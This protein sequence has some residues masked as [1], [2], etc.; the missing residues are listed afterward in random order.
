MRSAAGEAGTVPRPVVLTVPR[1]D[2]RAPAL[3]PCWTALWR[4]RLL[5]WAAGCVAFLALGTASGALHAFDPAGTS[6]SFGSLGNVLAAPAVRW[7]SIWYLQIAHDGY[8]FAQEASFYPLYPIL[9]RVGSLLTGSLVIAGLLL[10][11]GAMFAGLVIVRRLTELE[12]G[13]RPA[14]ATVNLIAFGPMA[15]FLSALYTESLF[16]L[17]SA[18][19]FYAARR[20]RWW[21]AGALGGLAALTRVTGVLLLVPVLLMF[22]YGPRSDLGPASVASRWRPRY[23][24]TP[25]IL[26]SALIPGGAALFSSYLA[27]RGFGAAAT[28]H[29]QQQFFDHQ[30]VGPLV[31]LWD[32]AT[33]AWHEV[34]LEL[35]GVPPSTYSSQALLQFGALVLAGVAL[36]G[37]F[38]R[39]P[40]AYGAYAAL[41]LL[42]PLSSPT[43]GDPLRGLDRY[44][45]VLF[46]LYMWAGAWAV[47]HRAVRQLVVL[48]CLLL[49]FFSAQFATW[50]WVGTPLL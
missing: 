34:R 20:G 21:A 7:D 50:H 41:G 2:A 26:W 27:V 47:E 4:S 8:R 33:A 14:S 13:V 45:S 32:G 46:P 30:L 16:L 35:A 49:A 24:F 31:G 3:R 40:I 11:F 6:G 18:G 9:V 10:S 39:L 28:I 37:V 22:F 38:R 19:A 5:I 48:S 42:I 17:L 43:V 15:L 25:A 1:V 44:A 29:G 23:R 12:F 36:C